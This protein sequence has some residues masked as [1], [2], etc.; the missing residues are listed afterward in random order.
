MPVD[1]CSLLL[2]LPVALLIFAGKPTTTNQ[3]PAADL[4][5]CDCDGAMSVRQ[6]EHSS[7]HGA[8]N[9]GGGQHE[10]SLPGGTPEGSRHTRMLGGR[11]TIVE[12]YGYSLITCT[13]NWYIVPL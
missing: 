11:A 1:A 2:V 4:K 8:R 3:W 13:K 12:L 9:P 10:R 5:L 6:R 7:A